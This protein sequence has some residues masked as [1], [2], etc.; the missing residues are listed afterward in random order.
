MTCEEFLALLDADGGLDSEE[1]ASHLASCA[2]CRAEAERWKMT[3]EELA[4]LR[5]APPPPFLHERIMTSVRAAHPAPVPAARRFGR[6]APWAMPVAALLLAGL[7]GGYALLKTLRKPQ[8][9]EILPAPIIQAPSH[10]IRGEAP[11]EDRA[12]PGEAEAKGNTGLLHEEPLQPPPAKAAPAA[13]APYEISPDLSDV[14]KKEAEA[15]RPSPPPLFGGSAP[16]TT[17]EP[18]AQPSPPPAADEKDAPR[19]ADPGAR[20]AA[21]SGFA[22]A[23]SQ[24][25]PAPSGPVVCTL[26]T[27]DRS[28]FVTLQLPSASAP[29]P[30]E[31]WYATLNAEG[32][33]AGLSGAKVRP[34]EE[35]LTSLSDAI[36]AVRLPAGRYQIKRI[37]D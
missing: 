2:A 29:P 34:S 28:R 6:R 1:A 18:Q 3:R 13:P 30:G 16:S 19:Q 23:R 27:L 37:S 12:N 20:D 32:R 5:D 31:T 35:A 25:A 14:R 15:P 9:P 10:A 24:A 4:A 36:A 11:S 22:A 26:S 8:A 7:F 33:L 21:E 17:A